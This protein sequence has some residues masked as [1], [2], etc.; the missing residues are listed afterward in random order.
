MVVNPRGEAG[1]DGKMRMRLTLGF[2]MMAALAACSP[3]I[4]DSGAA[5][6]SG[7]GV[8]FKDYAT[9]QREKAARETALASGSL[10]PPNVISE[11]PLD[12]TDGATVAP[13]ISEAE[14]IAAEARAALDSTG[15]GFGSEDGSGEAPLQATPSNPAPAVINEV[16]IS[17]ENSFDAV[18]SERSIEEDAARIARNREQYRV[19]EPEEI[20][21]RSGDAGPNIVAYALDSQH[22]VGTQIYR[23]I[24]IATAA[25][26]ERNCAEYASSDQ[27]QLDFLSRGGP[28][29]DRLA[30]DPDGDGYACGWDPTP[31]RR[32]VSE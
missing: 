29:R 19:I 16:G 25:R 14:R 7:T 13:E 32:A 27:A 28:Q 11:E 17:E 31:F 10:P 8:G 21:T 12:A 2:V 3:V 23:R 5:V 1:L 6:D 18:D 9:Y 22:P 20:G 4:P 26:N 30:L 15:A 24:G